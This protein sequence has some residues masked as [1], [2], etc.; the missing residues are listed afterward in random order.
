MQRKKNCLFIP[1]LSLEFVTDIKPIT[2]TFF[3]YWR[4]MLTEAYIYTLI[5]FS[6]LFF[7]AS[8][9]EYFSMQMRAPEKNS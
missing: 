5:S 7:C 1:T 9:A 4:W 2:D 8:L 6:N 3:K